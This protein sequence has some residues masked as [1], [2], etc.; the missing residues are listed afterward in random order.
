LVLPFENVGVERADD[1]K[2]SAFEETIS[3][4]FESAGYDVVDPQ[5][6]NLSLVELGFVPGE[7]ISRATAIVLGKE[8]D[9]Q[10]L[11]VGA[12]RASADRLDVDARVVDLELGATVGVV[13]DYAR[14]DELAR[15]SNQLAKNLFRLEAHAA[16]PGFDKRAKRRETLSLAALEASA[17]ARVSADPQVQR[18]Q[19]ER[20]LEHEPD[21]VEASVMLGRLLLHAGEPREAIDR[22]VHAGD[23]VALHR[24]AYFDLGLAYLAVNEP[25]SAFKVFAGS[26]SVER[27]EAASYNNQGVALMRLERFLPAVEAFEQAVAAEPGHGTYHFNLGF[28]L[29]RAGKGASALAQFEEA[30]GLMPWDG[31]A[32]LLASAAA[33]SQARGDLAERARATALVLAPQLE[34]VDTATVTDWARPVEAPV[35]P[36]KV[37]IEEGED[38]EAL[39]ELLDARALRQRGRLDEAIHLLQR[40]LYRE[41]GATEFRH[42]LVQL[43]REAGD[44]DLAARELSMLLWAEPTAA[45]HLELA[46]VYLE[47]DEPSKAADEVEKA[48]ILEP[49]HREAQQL[50]K[51]LAPPVI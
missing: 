26:T 44:L 9:A 42:E 30:S 4:H 40:T 15:L 23:D 3:A 35:R 19:L 17:L 20:A 6:R 50:R 37:D 25:E 7:P 16:P 39:V 38:V 33:F 49:D 21:Y 27:L 46:E 10:R 43:H 47:L 22:L 2:G 5:T 45:T 34:D 12:F 32:H 36:F 8:L 29:W 48:L 11:V 13:D 31:Q 24:A 1:W 28:S 41:P 51:E 18:R 14:G